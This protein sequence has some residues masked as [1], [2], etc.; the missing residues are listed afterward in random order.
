VLD[1]FTLS[2]TGEQWHEEN[3]TA[4]SITFDYSLNATTIQDGT[5]TFSTVPA[6]DF[7]SPT[8]VTATST[9]LDGNAAA[10]RSVIGPVTVT[11][12]NWQPGAD[13]WIRWS[14][15]NDTGRDQG[16]GLDD[17]SFS[18]DV[19]AVPEPASFALALIA[20]LIGLARRR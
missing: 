11:G 10:N 19:A 20:C 15:I 13:L 16:M 17:L 9:A 5:A 18:A 7:T 12:L 4:Q 2:Y 8:F 6:L 14:D 3:T 1:S